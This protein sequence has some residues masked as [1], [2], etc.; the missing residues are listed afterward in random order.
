MSTYQGV[1]IPHPPRRIST[2]FFDE[3]GH[4]PSSMTTP[5][6][7]AFIIGISLVPVRYELC[8]VNTK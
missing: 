3:F 7:N 4:I 8:P 5:L 1:K 2:L 6:C